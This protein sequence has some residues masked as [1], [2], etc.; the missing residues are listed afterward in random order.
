[1]SWSVSALDSQT[2]CATSTTTSSALT[3]TSILHS[4][5]EYKSL[6]TR[7]LL[8]RKARFKAPTMPAAN[9]TPI[10]NA[11]PPKL[12]DYDSTETLDSSPLNYQPP[13]YANDRRP[14][15]ELGI[16]QEI[17]NSSLRRKTTRR[18]DL[19]TV[20][21]PAF[22]GP[23]GEDY[24]MIGCENKPLSPNMQV[25]RP[26]PFTAAHPTSHGLTSG[27]DLPKPS[28][29]RASKRSMPRR[30]VNGETPRYI[31]H[32]ESQLA[33]L[34]TQLVS[35]T[36]PSS[37]KSISVK[38]RA[39]NSE[40]RLLRQEVSAWENKFHE[41]LR[42]Q[43][44]Q[45][46]ISTDELKSR[47]RTLERLVEEANEKVK[48]LEIVL[49]ERAKNLE[50][51][52][53]ANYDLERRLEFMSELLATS[54]RK[55]DSHSNA[56]P[57]IRPRPKSMGPPR[58]PSTN[59]LLSPTRS[60][61]VPRQRDRDNRPA[62]PTPRDRSDP[63]DQ[64]PFG[65]LLSATTNFTFTTDLG[66]EVDV[67]PLNPSETSPSRRESLL[68]CRSPSRE[69]NLRPTRRMRRFYTG[70]MGPRSLILPATQQSGS[71]PAASLFPMTPNASTETMPLLDK[72]EIETLKCGSPPNSRS[73][74]R[75]DKDVISTHMVSQPAMLLSPS[76]TLPPPAS[77][78]GRPSHIS[79]ES[80]IQSAAGRVLSLGAVQGRNLFEELSRMKQD[81]DGGEDTTPDSRP[82]TAGKHMGSPLESSCSTPLGF[83]R[84]PLQPSPVFISAT[85]AHPET[86]VPDD[87]MR[88]PPLTP[89]MSALSH[90]T[91]VVS[92][93][94]DSTAPSARRILT[95]AWSIITLSRP[96]LEFRWWLARLL[97][98]DLQKKRRMLRLS[99]SGTGTCI[100][101][102]APTPTSPVPSTPRQRGRTSHRKLD[103]LEAD[104]CSETGPAPNHNEELSWTKPG[105]STPRPAGWLK[106]SMTLVFA[107]VI[108]I[109]DG[110]EVLF[111]ADHQV[112][113]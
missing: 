59:S 113:Q 51:A 86:C 49:E 93:T 58:M 107:V 76:S 85:Q 32:L 108:A 57:G 3:L 110:P 30:S 105:Y 20:K 74:A 4:P 48:E 87:P 98:G 39:M 35:L 109:R 89:P 63:W 23:F 21:E 72:F 40:S 99:S 60:R 61:Q 84:S 77:L 94:L 28:R 104:A 100:G 34:Q 42:E 17:S 64:S 15:N 54:P 46:E 45:H 9:I 55:V 22:N 16:L 91:S 82:S 25:R 53:S 24:S 69:T 13:T 71:F 56:T 67:T 50:A 81:H 10:A 18:P 101:T 5:Q 103:D 44:E 7:K 96:V 38:L 73:S 11:W 12:I 106:L 66:S 2:A 79:A 92:R 8:V 75:Q 29:G 78:S 112:P 19:G 1:M 26:H 111:R 52:E 88:S 95:N 70:S 36:S 90:T 43:L 6:Q 97:L 31:E 14:S 65:E 68:H 83:T 33:V 80:S 62:S 41:R 102:N 47:I 37:N 27:S